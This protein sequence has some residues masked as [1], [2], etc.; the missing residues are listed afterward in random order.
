[1]KTKHGKTKLA[2]QSHYE[3]TVINPIFTL[4]I[5]VK[6]L[7]F[8]FRDIMI[9]QKRSCI[10]ITAENKFFVEWKQGLNKTR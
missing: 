7:Q 4:T 5:N 8:R 1:M 2:H 10:T 6:M 3:P 9:G